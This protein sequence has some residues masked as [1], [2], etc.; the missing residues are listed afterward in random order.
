MAPAPCT[1]PLPPCPSGIH[2]KSPS[3]GRTAGFSIRA[4]HSDC[5]SGLA[6]CEAASQCWW[7]GKET[8]PKA[9]EGQFLCSLGRGYIDYD[10]QRNQ[11]YLICWS[12]LPW[13]NPLPQLPVAGCISSSVKNNT[14]LR[15]VQGKHWQRQTPSAAHATA[16]DA[17]TR[18]DAGFGKICS[19]FQLTPLSWEFS[20]SNWECHWLETGKVL[21]ASLLGFRTTFSSALAP[22]HHTSLQKTRVIK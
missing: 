3:S 17:Q 8:E 2:L 6:S 9:D 21:L 14:Q 18:S 1:T 7:M 5:G 11:I 15:A 4:A 10:Y 16:P 20:I 22:L 13:L 12:F 19:Y